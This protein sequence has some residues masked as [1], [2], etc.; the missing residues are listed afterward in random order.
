[1]DKDLELRFSKK[2]KKDNIKSILSCIC[3]MLILGI[4]SAK[5]IMNGGIGFMTVFTT[6]LF[7]GNL[8][9]LI[10]CGCRIIDVYRK[11][12]IKIDEDEVKIYKNTI[13][14]YEIINIKDIKSYAVK[15]SNF[16]ILNEKSSSYDVNL[17][18][19]NTDDIEKFKYSLENMGV[20][21]KEVMV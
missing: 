20:L 9:E 21:R 2:Y 13:S 10:V 19:L 8:V 7:I 12:Y 1:M 14:K 15:N 11:A 4:I 17:E 3:Y 5:H 16:L 18:K 6:I